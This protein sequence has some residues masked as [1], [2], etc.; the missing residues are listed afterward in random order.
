MRAEKNRVAVSLM[1]L[2]LKYPNPDF[3]ELDKPPMERKVVERNGKEVV[4]MKPEANF[5]MKD[6]VIHARIKG[7]DH[8][9][10]F[11]KSNFRAMRMAKSLK[12][13]D[14]DQLGTV[15]KGFAKVTRF[16][17]AI[18][19]QY[20]PVFGAVNFIRD[21]QAGMLHLGSTPLAGQ[22]KKV[23]GYTVDALR[24]GVF[25]AI[26]D[27]RQGKALNTK[28]AW[29]GWLERYEKAGGKVGFSQMFS[30][31]DDRAKAIENE[32]KDIGKSNGL[33]KGGEILGWLSDYNETAENAVRLAAFR[34]AVEKFES[35][36]MATPVA[37]QKAAVLAKNLTVNFNRKG[38]I[39]T[40]ANALYAF[41]NASVQGSARMAE[42]MFEFKGGQRDFKN[43]RL[44]P[45]GK[46]ILLGGILLGVSQAVLLS[47]MGMGG[48][49]GPEEW[50]KQRA[51]IIPGKDKNYVAI[52]M[53][54]G[55]HMLVNLGRI[56]TEMVQGGFKNKFD[57]M[58]NMVQVMLDGFNPLGSATLAQ[59]LSPSITDIPIA[60]AEN[61]DWAGRDISM[62]PY[63]RN[64]RRPGHK[65]AKDSASPW[66]RILSEG[67]NTISGGS[68]HRP[69]RWSPTPDQIDYVI[70]QLGGGVMREATKAGSTFASQVT[71]EEIPAY[72]VPFSGR[73][74]GN[75]ADQAAIRS[76]F[77]KHLN[78]IN[79]HEAEIKGMRKDGKPD[80]EIF[81]YKSRNP[82][83]RLIDMGNAAEKRLRKLRDDRRDAVKEGDKPRVKSIEQEITSV[84][85]DFN[86][87]YARMLELKEE[88]SEE[89]MSEAEAEE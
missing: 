12:N 70:E 46:K 49:D 23:A 27:Q 74:I 55:F 34:A 48:D 73:F 22:K 88:V 21:F 2:A 31:A 40:Q 39:S 10:V 19:T 65:R 53:P 85:S 16:F 28:N 37:E 68:D 54:L 84:M 79:D 15:M 83:S 66:A 80:D 47:A 24:G 77:Y 71:G 32:I 25:Q 33:K 82:D 57:H 67:L 14:A 87:R 20:N 42:T 63:G 7:Q 36:G 26:R 3:W 18:N 8:Y 86:E 61:K 50:I 44:S 59:T 45:L 75:L 52:P 58:I 43:V 89:N 78:R 69:G 1:G 29:A 13:V 30:T 11:N 72:K 60:L 4:E 56:P 38:Q 5:H 76:R 64:D 9:L 51:L 41:F 17:A 81:A 35:Q 6:N 62:E